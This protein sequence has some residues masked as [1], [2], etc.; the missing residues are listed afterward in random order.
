MCKIPLKNL[1]VFW[2]YSHFPFVLAA[3]A[4]EMNTS[5]NVKPEGYGNMWVKPLKLLPNQ[6]GEVLSKELKKLEREFRKQSILLNENFFD[7]AKQL[8]P[9]IK[10]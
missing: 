4:L 6:E 7:K 8:I 10:K 3:R 5:G 9:E 1:Y 2:T